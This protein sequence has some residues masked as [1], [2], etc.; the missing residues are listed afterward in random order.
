MSL[1]TWKVFLCSTS[2]DLGEQRRLT[3]DLLT[4]MGFE[5]ICFEDNFIIDP[6]TSS[7][8]ICVNN[9]RRAD[10]MIML[11]DRVYGKNSHADSHVSVPH[12]EYLTARDAGIPVFHF[13][14]RDL[15][16]EFDRMGVLD[17]IDGET[18]FYWKT[19]RPEYVDRLELVELVR[20][21][22]I[23]DADGYATFF[24]SWQELQ[25]GL[26]KRTRD[27]SIVL[28][29]RLVVGQVAR[30]LD[31][32]TSSQLWVTIRQIIGT[33]IYQRPTWRAEFGDKVV[34][35]S[36]TPA[37]DEQLRGGGV[38]VLKGKAGAGKTTELVR[39]L[40]LLSD[41]T[42]SGDVLL[43]VRM[44]DLPV[45]N[46]AEIA[47]LDVVQLLV[48]TILGKEPYPSLTPPTGDLRFLFDG[49]DESPLASSEEGLESLLGSPAFERAGVV[50]TRPEAARLAARAAPDTLR[51]GRI[52]ELLDWDPPTALNYFRELLGD[53]SGVLPASQAED[54]VL[55]VATNPLTAVLL[56]YIIKDS[57]CVWP[58]DLGD[59]AAVYEEFL[60]RWAR[61]EGRKAPLVAAPEAFSDAL[62]TAWRMTAWLLYRARQSSG[63]VVTYS[64]VAAAGRDIGIDVAALI[65]E[66]AYRSL[67][68]VAPIIDR[69][70]GFAHD[71]FMEYLTARHYCMLCAQSSVVVDEYL[72]T[73]IIG[74][75]NSFIKAIWARA[76]LEEREG[77]CEF[78]AVRFAAAQ[79]KSDQVQIKANIVYYW[80]HLSR[81]GDLGDL[82]RD[83]LATAARDAS[84]YVRNGAL[85]SLVRMGD[86]RAERRLYESLTGDGDANDFNRRLHLEYFGDVSPSLAKPARDDGSSSWDRSYT[87]LK[88]HLLSL[89]R[90]FVH[91]KRVDV[92][93]L[94]SL[95]TAR[96]DP[97]PVTLPD[98]SEMRNAILDNIRLHDGF[99][100][101]LRAALDELATFEAWVGEF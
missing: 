43:Y 74:E 71:Q 73:S 40:S 78:L 19:M 41:R 64:D 61:R 55:R 5:V 56:A 32:D 21:L 57:G 82:V 80:S 81:D 98:F 45:T 95:A 31:T 52:V 59:R 39:A 6:E 20:D 92:V 48:A 27:Y 24:D 86:M 18:R 60:V 65:R 70:L 16:K 29:R 44:R 97:G 87:S 83:K 96:G 69:I 8:A 34:G 23:S 101:V 15:K 90:R 11:L 62:L 72:R 10:F 58:T 75:V 68:N 84:A 42:E 37:I 94:R 50:S 17:R 91:S 88:Q 38:M 54:V 63:R 85:F 79:G 46:P 100:E 33:E 12:L 26:E 30:L 77:V 99:E 66:P 93:T 7:E 13:L 4:S 67:L 47:D 36:L 9:V 28:Y 89:E 76:P 2:K 1:A 35:T 49:L 22:R 14:S 53:A 25:S 51:L 3:R